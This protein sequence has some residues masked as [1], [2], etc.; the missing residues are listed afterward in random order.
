[1]IKNIE[2]IYNIYDGGLILKDRSAISTIKGYF[3]QLD[4]SILKLLQLQSNTDIITVE[5]IE[6]LDISTLNNDTAIQCKYYEKTEYNHSEIAEPIRLMLYDYKIRKDNEKPLI[7]YQLY[8]YY[9]SGQQKLPDDIS[10]DFLKTHFLTFSHEKQVI[11]YY[12][13][14]KLNDTDLQEFLSNLKL[15]I[16]AEEYEQ[17]L[18]C[19]YIDLENRFNCSRFEAEYYYYNNALRLI[20]ELATKANIDE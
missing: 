14:L 8:G 20:K 6:D 4:Y 16:N 2:T 1:M 18:N 9:K 11:K 10:L 13:E 7:S 3:Y 19:I 5:G 15:Q 12:E 17:Q